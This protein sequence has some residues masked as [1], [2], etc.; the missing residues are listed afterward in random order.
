MSHSACLHVLGLLIA[1]GVFTPLK[2]SLSLTLICFLLSFMFPP[3]VPILYSFLL[4]TSLLFLSPR[5][6]PSQS[7]QLFSSH[8]MK[9]DDARTK[10]SF[11]FCLRIQCEVLKAALTDISVVFL[12]TN[13]I[14]SSNSKLKPHTDHS[15]FP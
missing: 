8:F 6:S 15:H 13:N 9:R 1:L 4:S 7:L 5:S 14:F 12:L 11:S 3:N 2:L 10:S